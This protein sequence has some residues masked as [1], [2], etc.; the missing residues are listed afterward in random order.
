MGKCVLTAVAAATPV[1]ETIGVVTLSISGDAEWA[2]FAPIW[3]TWWLGDLAGALVVTPVIVEWATTSLKEADSAEWLETAAAFLFAI[4]IGLIAF[5]PLLSVTSYNGALAFLAI[6]PLTWSAL[7]RNERDT[8]TA[9]FLLAA[10]AVWATAVDGGPFARSTINDS[11][12]LLISFL[13]AVALPSLA[14]SA[15]VASWRRIGLL[16][17]RSNEALRVTGNR[18]IA[19]LQAQVQEGK[20]AL[21]A[22]EQQLAQ[23]QKME[24]LGQLTGGIAHDFN[25][26]LMI[27]G[28]QA[29]I[30]KRLGADPK[31]LRALDSIDTAVKRGATLTRQLLMFARRQRLH[32]AVIDLKDRVTEFKELLASSVGGAAIL[33]IDV[34]DDTWPVEVDVAEF[35]LAIVNL[36]MNARD[37]MEQGGTVTLGAANVHLNGTG[38]AALSGDFVALSVSD[39]G[40]GIAEHI[41]P[42]IFE[43]FFTTKAVGKGTGLGLSQVYGFAHQSG[44]AVTAESKLGHGTR[45]T[46]YLPRSR[47]RVAEDGKA[48]P[49]PVVE[50]GDGTILVVEDNAEVAAVSTA[51][52][53]QI[54][55]RV[56]VASDAKSALEA[57][58]GE[59]D[60]R[61]L[62]SDIVMPGEMD[63]LALANAARARFPELPILLTSGYSKAADSAG[64][65]F[66]ILRKPY[67]L[68]AL[69]VA[70]KTAMSRGT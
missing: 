49:E 32:P 34:A 9:A 16:L 68:D 50:P 55:Y 46:L 17:K 33:K 65:Q 29:Q 36:V 31:Q 62:F 44:G 53:E 59:A 35:E 10:C 19:E 63:G 42:R 23:A 3:T 58:N 52:L 14:L 22:T 70:V 64:T 61:L 54:G 5:S 2:N 37:A 15:S 41:L 40:T 57:L 67:E 26:L 56:I 1:S 13:I 18:E 6:A 48:A 51:L 8:A 28:G 4:L 11:F 45:L 24:A 47:S 69:A 30:L 7:R 25:N 27:V 20:T 12:L 21:S 43:P 66:P 39:T 60:I 38:N